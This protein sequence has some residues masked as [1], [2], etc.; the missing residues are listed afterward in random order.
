ME[1]V[2]QYPG[3]NRL[4]NRVFED[5]SAVDDACRK[6][7]D[8]LAAAPDRIDLTMRREWAI[9]PS[10]PNLAIMDDHQLGLISLARVR[11]P[12]AA[13]VPCA[14]SARHSPLP[15]K[16]AIF[17]AC[18]SEIPV[19]GIR[20]PGTVSSG[21]VRNLTSLSLVQISASVSNAAEKS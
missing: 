3:N 11:S 16:S 6:A 12:S 8:W 2:F 13:V 21:A 7:W 15:R 9:V 10:S 17:R 1:T 19:F 20:L 5:V 4:A 14:C 18:I